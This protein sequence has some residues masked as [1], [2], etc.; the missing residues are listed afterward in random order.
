MKPVFPRKCLFCA[1]QV[2]YIVYILGNKKATL[3]LSTLTYCNNTILFIFSRCTFNTE[4][5]LIFV[6]FL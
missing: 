2:L 1:I 5:L 4:F 3:S 6:L